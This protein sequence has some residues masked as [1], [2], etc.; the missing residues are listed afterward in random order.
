MISEGIIAHRFWA[1]IADSKTTK[2]QLRIC[3]AALLNQAFPLGM[4]AFT[5]EERADAVFPRSRKQAMA[6]PLLKKWLVKYLFPFGSRRWILAGRCRGMRVNLTRDTGHAILFGGDRECH[7]FL[8]R[9]IKAGNT[10]YDVGANIGEYT[11]LFAR[12]AG[13]SGRVIAFEPLPKVYEQLA[14]HIQL[15][16]LSQAVCLNLA[17]SDTEG[18]VSFLEDPEHA[19]QGKIQGVEPLNR[20]ENTRSLFVETLPL[21]ALWSKKNFPPPDLVKIDT[22]GSAAKIIEG[23]RLTIEKF[24]PSFYVELHGPEERAGVQSLCSRGYRLEDLRG[25]PIADLT[26]E[27]HSPVWAYP[28]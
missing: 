16:R 14:A 4:K 3:F 21:D 17:L 18:R 12:C 23:A 7:A 19:S 2:S 10:V 27:W 22:E 1:L 11:L 13:A 25:K 24:R 28:V 8:E 15:N 20:L 26:A 6:D 9:K 5:I